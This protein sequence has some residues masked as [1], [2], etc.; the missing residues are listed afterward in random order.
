MVTN[1]DTGGIQSSLHQKMG[2]SGEVFNLCGD[3]LQNSGMIKLKPGTKQPQS[4]KK[5]LLLL[6]YSLK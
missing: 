2:F 6:K 5:L 4:S 1:N 3:I